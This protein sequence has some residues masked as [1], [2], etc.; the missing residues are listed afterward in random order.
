MELDNIQAV[1]KSVVRTQFR[2]MPVCLTRELLYLLAADQGTG[3][4]QMIVCPIRVERSDG[5]YQWPVLKVCVVRME[6]PRL[7][8]GIIGGIARCNGHRT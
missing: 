2:K 4:L 3:M 6:D 8:K 1:A 5:F 7:V